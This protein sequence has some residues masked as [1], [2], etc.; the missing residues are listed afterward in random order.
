VF[1]PEEPLL[2]GAAGAALLAKDMTM[3]AL[4][5]GKPVRKGKRSLE[6]ATFFE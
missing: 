3:K 2:T 6:E 1:V 5:E 4:A